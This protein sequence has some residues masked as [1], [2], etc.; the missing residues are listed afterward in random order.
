MDEEGLSEGA[1]QALIAGM[2]GAEE[3]RTDFTP[4]QE[5]SSN[6]IT[7][8]KFLIILRRYPNGACFPTIHRVGVNPVTTKKRVT[9][10]V[11]EQPKNTN[12]GEVGLI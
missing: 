3:K 4:K 10:K 11:L 2:M 1:V 6:Q 7:E 9:K 8:E 12:V 5:F